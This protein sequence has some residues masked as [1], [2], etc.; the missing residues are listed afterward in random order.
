MGCLRLIV[1]LKTA[2]G[3]ALWLTMVFASVKAVHAAERI[4]GSELHTQC[5]LFGDGVA[6]NYYSGTC[7]GYIIGVIDSHNGA[8][9]TEK[10]PEPYFCLPKDVT[11]GHLIDIVVRYVAAH[12]EQWEFGAATLV[13]IALVM[14]YPCVD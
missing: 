7:A 6:Y 11:R 12:P 8:A 4:D 5:R 10:M 3:I 9:G 14:E 13:W 1:T 2:L